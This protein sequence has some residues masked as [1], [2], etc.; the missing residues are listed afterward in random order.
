MAEDSRLE[1]LERRVRT[2]PTSVVFAALAEEYRRAGRFDEAIEI[3][4]RG[5]TRHPAYL[6]ARVTLGR[7]LIEV[8]A[9]QEAEAELQRV[10]EAAPENLAAIRGLAELHARTGETVEI[11]PATDVASDEPLGPPGPALSETVGAA[12]PVE[13]MET[14]GP[15]S[16]GA[17]PD[18]AREV[19]MSRSRDVDPTLA[20]LEVFLRAIQTARAQV[21][22]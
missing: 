3:C 7:A 12:Q 14:P 21:R 18:V 11:V 5:L 17:P 9:L 13:W 1:Q 2:D 4:R 16:T 20:A 22:P 8:G 10:L 6:S 15:D 19:G